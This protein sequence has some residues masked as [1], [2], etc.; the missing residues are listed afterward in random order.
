M[1]TDE[2]AGSTRS[3]QVRRSGYIPTLDGWRTIAVFAVIAFHARPLHIGKLNLG[4]LQSYGD[5]GVQLFFAISGILIC[6]RLLEEQRL[7]GTISLRGFYVRRLFRIQPAAI[8]MLAAVVLLAMAG[9][10][11]VGLG[12]TMA[13]LFSFRNFFDALGG[14]TT[15]DD[16][17]TVHFWSLAVEEHFYL[18]LPALLILARRRLIPVLVTLA[19]VSM[20]WPPMAHRWGFT[21]N[22]FSYKRTDLALQD[23]LVPALLAVLLTYPAVR[24]LMLRVSGR[25]VL[26]FAVVG[27][28]LLSERFAGGHLTHQITCVGFPL[29]ITSTM[30][31]P[32]EWLGRL[33]ET[34]LFTF[35]GRVSYSLYLWQQ[36]F[37]IRR[38]ETSVLHFVQSWPWN[39]AGALSFAIAS[40]F[41][42]EK[43]LI[44]LGHRFAPPAT[45]GRADLQTPSTDLA[46]DRMAY[47]GASTSS[48]S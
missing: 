41:F 20:I 43:P 37:F 22:T 38:T 12:A 15:P 42:I 35:L 19:C 45:P 26:I 6:S 27:A 40:Y 17:Y 11:H 31:H 30:L 23:L 25:G 3:A 33:L 39:L 34:R 7:H 21:E 8:A 46:S 48:K 32:E 36:L 13:S 4:G 44:R 24:A 2:R 29:I 5:R 10:L 9:V 18:L 28:I 16:R 1:T 14:T 47:R